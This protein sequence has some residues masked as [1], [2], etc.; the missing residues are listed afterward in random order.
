VYLALPL[1][2]AALAGYALS[3]WVAPRLNKGATRKA[4][5]FLAGAAGVA[6]LVRY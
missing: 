6:V 4:V 3:G 1:V 2:P 5:L